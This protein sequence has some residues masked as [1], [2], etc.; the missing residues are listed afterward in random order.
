M[1][2][3]PASSESRVI[4]P[5]NEKGTGFLRNLYPDNKSYLGGL[6]SEKEFNNCI[7]TAAKLT[8]K[9][10]SHNRKKDVEGISLPVYL[11]LGLTSAMIFVY[12]FFMY[13]GIKDKK[14][15]LT[16]IGIF[17]LAISVFIV[18]VLSIVNLF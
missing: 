17:L 9:V 5:S 8:A 6:I 1:V 7:D 4:I 13:F 11:T 2:F 14:E 16:T 12:F 15:G 3:V 10:Y 18:I